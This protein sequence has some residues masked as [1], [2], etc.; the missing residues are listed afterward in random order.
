MIAQAPISHDEIVS[1]DEEP[2]KK[3]V[4]V[5]EVGLLGK[6]EWREKEKE[7]RKLGKGRK[8]WLRRVW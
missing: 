3:E 7:K 4:K 5:E 2:I 1:E 8:G 6:D